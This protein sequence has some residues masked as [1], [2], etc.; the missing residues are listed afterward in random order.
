MS[1]TDNASSISRQQLRQA[2]QQE[3]QMRVDE[4]RRRIAEV[5]EELECAA[6][7]V[8]IIDGSQIS[9]RIEIVAL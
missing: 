1:D 5:L 4:A 8:V 6:K 3:A 7:P 9:T 2:A